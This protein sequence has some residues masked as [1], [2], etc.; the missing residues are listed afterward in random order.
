MLIGNAFSV[1]HPNDIR[2]ADRDGRDEQRR[3][4]FEHLLTICPPGKNGLQRE[5]GHK[6]TGA[7]TSFAGKDLARQLQFTRQLQFI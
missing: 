6:T 1:V 5:R 2:C 4:S 7:E 3:G